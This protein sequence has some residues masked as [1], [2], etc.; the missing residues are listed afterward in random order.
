[1]RSSSQEMN[2]LMAMHELR[3]GGRELRTEKPASRA[4]GHE[5]SPHALRAARLG[6]PG[7]A[8]EVGSAASET[9]VAAEPRITA[10][11][12]VTALEGVTAARGFLASG[13]HCGIR[14][15]RSDWTPA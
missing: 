11:P 6:A 4:G 3:P 10:A 8:T 1:M 5:R 13:I 2:W 15:K 9:V 14:K 7:S 12:D